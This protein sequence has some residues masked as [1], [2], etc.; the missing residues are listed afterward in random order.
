MAFRARSYIL[1]FSIFFLTSLSQILSQ[2]R[3][4][5]RN[6]PDIPQPLVN[7]FQNDYRKLINLNGEWSV[8]STDPIINTRIFVPFCYDFKGKVTA[9]RQ[10]NIELNNP[11]E[12][13]YIIHAEGINYQSEISINGRFVV[14]HEGGFTSFST[15][16]VE[17]LIKEANNVIEIKIDNTL[18]VSRTIPL[19]NTANYPKNYGGI[20]RDIYILAVPKIF[21]K[22]VNVFSEIDIN[23]NAD[24][25]NIITISAT[26]ISKYTGSDKK[27]N[28]RTELHDSLGNVKASS[29]AV[30]ISTAPNSTSQSENILTLASPIYWSPDYPYLYKLKVIISLDNEII[31]IYQT[32]FGIYELSRKSGTIALNRSELKF[33]GINYVEEYA[34]GLCGSYDETARDIR[35]LKSLGC[36]IIKVYGKPA[37]SYLV[38]LCNKNG[39]LIMEELPVHTVPASV[40]ENENFINL[41][42]NQLNE[43]IASHKNNPCIFAY[44]LGNDFDVSGPEGRNFVKRLS[45]ISKKTDNRLVY[46]ST[47]NY[48]EDKCRE[49][50]DLTGLNYYDGDPVILKNIIADTKLKKE[51]IFISNYGKVINPANLSGYSDP[52]SLEA[53]SKFIV[54]FYKLYKSSPFAGAFFQS[55]ADWNSDI[56]NLRFFDK[57]NQYMRTTGLYTLFREERPPAVIMRKHLLEEDIPNLNIGTYSREAPLVFVLTGLI[58]FILFI[59]LANSVR[60]FRE[61]VNRAIFR[62]FIFFTDVREQ[63]LIPVFHNILL[64][65]IISFG[66]GLFFANLL[67]FWK[68][69]QLLDIVL[70]VLITNDVIKLYADQIII[71]PVNLVLTLTI[72]T[73]IRIFFIAF[74]IWL[75]SL[76]IKYRIGFGNIYTVTVWGLLPTIL[77]LAA[78]TF[79][80]RILNVNTDFVSIGLGLAV[81]LYVISIY[82]ILKGTYIIFDTFFVKVYAYGI[83][84]LIVIGSAFWYYLNSS[85]LLFDYIGLV[86]LFLKN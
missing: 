46:Y 12:W 85:R 58:T 60:R 69:S 53:Q 56:P 52:A 16:I 81:L 20:Y 32:D 8:T 75:F 3:L 76:S 13:N 38:D 39:L 78:G 27:L 35:N 17:G 57:P 21:V 42:E 64:A 44:G 33:K 34:N 15:P 1:I 29:D 37:S 80:I 54:D 66:N 7:N 2:N 72:I 77:L 18:D 73:F 5:S 49:L 23:L 48:Y 26:D 41:A 31:D 50:V 83:I 6:N 45:G 86:F 71:N 70:S 79:Y 68:D 19:K 67:Y 11:N 10:F 84:T 9:H 43:M 30:F 63:N 28:I 65:V 40:L 22:S 47:R 82:R 51:K 25:K 62:P 14:K 24:I 36:N 59:Y 4:Y 74:I 55:Y 61:N